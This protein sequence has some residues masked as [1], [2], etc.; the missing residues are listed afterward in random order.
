MGFCDKDGYD[1]GGDSQEL[2]KQELVLSKQ[3][4]SL[5]KVLSN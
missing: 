3:L 2:E 1:N 5:Q 4:R